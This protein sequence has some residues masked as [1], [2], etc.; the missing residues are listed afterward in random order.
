MLIR[1]ADGQRKTLEDLRAAVR[2]NDAAGAAGFAHA[3]AGSAGNLGMDSLLRRQKRSR[4]RRA[5][6]RP[7]SRNSSAAVDAMRH[8]S[9]SIHRITEGEGA[10]RAGSR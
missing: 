8:C 9:L 4:R 1:F 2:T 3:L 5:R 7:I 10:S 6:D